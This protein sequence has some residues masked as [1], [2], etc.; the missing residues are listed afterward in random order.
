M[1]RYSR[2]KAPCEFC[3]ESGGHHD[4][5]DIKINKVSG[6]SEEGVNTITVKDL[7]GKLEHKRDL[8]I[9]VIFR[10]GS[11]AM[12]KHLDPELDHS[13]MQEMQKKKKD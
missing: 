11:G 7:Y 9:G 2:R 4:T 6:N 10:E 13:H 1:S 12:L 8:I 3:N 5:C